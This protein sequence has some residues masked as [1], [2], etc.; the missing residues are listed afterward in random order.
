MSDQIL[1]T[2]LSLVGVAGFM[3]AGR[4]VWWAW[5]VNIANQ[6]LWVAYILVTGHWGF[7]I[8]VVVYTWVFVGNARRWTRE[9]HE[10]VYEH[11]HG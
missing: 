10:D 9:H 7:A 4:K 5:H 6:F 3:L 11:E 8:G 2:L 1:P